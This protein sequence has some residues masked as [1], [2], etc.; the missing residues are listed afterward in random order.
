MLLLNQF[1][2]R[3][4]SDFTI[5]IA[6]AYY[7]VDLSLDSVSSLGDDTYSFTTTHTVWYYN[8]KGGTTGAFMRGRASWYHKQ[9]GLPG[10]VFVLIDGKDANNED[11]VKGDHPEK[12]ETI[13]SKRTFWSYFQFSTKTWTKL[14]PG[15]YH[16]V[17]GYTNL[18]G[19]WSNAKGANG[20]QIMLPADQNSLEGAFYPDPPG[21]PSPSYEM[22][23]A[24]G[25]GRSQSP[26]PP[27]RRPS[28]S[29]K[30]RE[31]LTMRFTAFFQ[32]AFLTAALLSSYFA[33]AQLPKPKENVL[34]LERPTHRFMRQTK[35]LSCASSTG[36]GRTIGCGWP[37]RASECVLQRASNGRRT[38]GAPPLSDFYGGGNYAVNV[39]NLS[40]NH[41]DI[42]T[43]PFEG[44]LSLNTPAWSRDSSSLLL[45]GFPFASR[46]FLVRYLQAGSIVGASE[47]FDKRARKSQ[48]NAFM[49]AC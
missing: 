14:Q 27:F 38:A 29:Q 33:A 26:G 44:K 4:E 20:A 17:Q 48:S 35:S 49:V 6:W 25:A 46:R 13:P 3:F 10:A 7:H 22:R 12:D 8:D 2:N 45:A 39:L 36:T 30:L 41:V 5:I 11:L 19:A 42:V 40:T 16:A 32:T 34:R 21:I 1:L 37:T 31:A 24:A 15:Y 9:H 43:K 18:D 28:V 47:K 23:R